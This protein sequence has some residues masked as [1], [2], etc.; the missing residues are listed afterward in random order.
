MRDKDSREKGDEECSQGR[1][2]QAPNEAVNVM[3]WTL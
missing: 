3:A 1:Q 2:L